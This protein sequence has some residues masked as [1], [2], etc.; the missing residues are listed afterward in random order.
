MAQTTKNPDI[1]QEKTMNPDMEKVKIRLPFDPRKGKGMYVNVNNNNF[2]IPRGEDVE[3]PR[4]IAK[5]IENSINQDEKT[6]RKI[7]ILSESASF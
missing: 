1:E 2:F 3:V 7:M 6:A 4:Y 5:V